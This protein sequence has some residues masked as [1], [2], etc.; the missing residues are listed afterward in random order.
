MDITSFLLGFESG[1][2]AASGDEGHP[3]LRYVTFMS[4]DG[5]VELGKKAVAV[6]DDCA[7]PFARGVIT[8]TPTR[9]SDVQYNYSFVG[10]ATESNGAW[11]EDA[12]KEVKQDRTVYAAYASAIRYYTITYYDSDGTTVLHTESVMY[13]NVPS[14]KPTHEELLFESW[15][16]EPT[17]VT[18][19]TSYIAVWTDKPSFAE[20]SWEKIAEISASGK[21]AEV[22]SIGDERI[23]TIKENGDK[24]AV[25]YHDCKVKIV[26]FNH[27]EKED[28]SKAGI[29]CLFFTLFG[30]RAFGSGAISN[31][32]TYV[33]GNHYKF[34]KQFAD[35]SYW[36]PA[37]LRAVIKPVKKEHNTA[38]STEIHTEYLGSWI[39]S[40]TELG[41]KDSECS[42]Q[43][44]KLGSRY[45]MFSERAYSSKASSAT[46]G[47][48]EV[49]I[50]YISNNALKNGTL[51]T[52]VMRGMATEQA[53]YIK[54]G[55][56]STDG[57]M[58]DWPGTSVTSYEYCP[59]GFCI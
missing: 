31:Y 16:P 4:H 9:E 27:D 52:A 41:Y 11:D 7:D 37:D 25:Y 26:G 44:V 17:A 22:F 14:Y 58:Y 24:G 35:T 43:K 36:L 53:A 1:K 34:A 28:G 33:T 55:P 51:T 57:T 32:P 56:Y 6:G 30:Q 8:Q 21:A 19:N 54:G 39:P 13:G 47:S 2:T 38:G 5:T 29:T 46:Y 50:E 49:K 48:M 20:S 40:L 18:G 23:I 59:I 3:D 12:L 45:E 42:Y 15:N 10:W